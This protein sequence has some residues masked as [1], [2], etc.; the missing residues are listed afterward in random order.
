MEKTAYLRI[1]IN[2]FMK[3]LPNVLTTIRII[4]A[5]GL[6]FL[7]SFSVAFFVVYTLCGLTDVL[8]GAIARS[9]G[10]ASEF[11]AKLDSIADSLFYTIML[12]K[13]L[14]TLW[15]RMP[16]TIW[17][18]IGATLFLRFCCYTL[19]AVKFHRFASLHTIL[20]KLGGLGVFC[21]PYLLCSP[22]AVPG[23]H[24]VALLAFV[25]AVY[26]LGLHIT[27]KEYKPDASL[28]K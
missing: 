23:C 26:E 5:L 25:G 17:Y 13:M 1:G 4:G 15:E 19:C 11:G 10:V 3:Y 2:Q 21:V 9:Q 7:P 12:L 28:S 20:N 27:R 14:P 24:A 6:I 16:V 22:I 8:D 18:I